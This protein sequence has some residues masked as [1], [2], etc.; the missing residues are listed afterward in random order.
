[1]QMAKNFVRHSTM[2]LGEMLLDPFDF[3]AAF[4]HEPDNAVH[5]AG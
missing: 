1:M 3:C 5:K 4:E 2:T